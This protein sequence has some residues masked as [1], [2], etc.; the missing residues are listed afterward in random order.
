[1]L[2]P[3]SRKKSRSQNHLLLDRYHL[4]INHHRRNRTT[5]FQ[6]QIRR[7]QR[8]IER[9]AYKWNLRY[10][11]RQEGKGTKRRGWIRSNDGARTISEE[12]DFDSFTGPKVLPGPLE[13]V[14]EESSPSDRLASSGQ[15]HNG[16]C[17][18]E[19]LPH[20]GRARAVYDP[21]LQEYFVWWTC[22]SA[23]HSQT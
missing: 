7:E 23:K 6:Q 14:Q 22:C 5:A 9:N 17:C 15:S 21:L 12:L 11:T 3:L 8:A 20:F 4:P 2:P 1:M 16:A 13:S 19:G 10:S 18:R